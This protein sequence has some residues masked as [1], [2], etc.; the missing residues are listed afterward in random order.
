MKVVKRSGEATIK[1]KLYKDLP[2]KQHLLSEIGGMIV[3][4][5]KSPYKLRILVQE[6]T[7]CTLRLASA[8]CCLMHMSQAFW[9]EFGMGSF[10]ANY[11]TKERELFIEKMTTT[12]PVEAFSLEEVVSDAPGP[13]VS[14]M[15]VMP[16]LPTSPRSPRLK[17]TMAKENQPTMKEKK[18]TAKEKQKRLTLVHTSARKHTEAQS[19]QKKDKKP[20]KV[21]DLEEEEYQGI[22][23]FNVEGVE[24]FSILAKYVT[25]WKRKTKVTKNPNSGK[26]R[27]STPLL[28]D[29]V[30]FEGPKLAH[31]PMLKLEDWDIV[32]QEKFPHMVT[33]QYMTKIYYDDAGVTKLE[34]TKWICSVEQSWLNYM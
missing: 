21:M 17:Q 16:I 30:T 14:N 15:E 22:E 2:P 20:E 31:M 7:L 12:N 18:P 33:H 19:K 13:K 32:D 25:L 3:F 29:Q 1:G 24:P 10:F 23:D 4:E 34:S 28:Q 11:S 9:E 27:I 6:R 26:F 5:L 8:F